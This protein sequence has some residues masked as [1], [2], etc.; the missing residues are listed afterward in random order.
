MK[1]TSP[2]IGKFNEFQTAKWDEKHLHSHCI[3]IMEHQNQV[4]DTKEQQGRKDL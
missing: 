1:A 3:E 2:Q 4:K